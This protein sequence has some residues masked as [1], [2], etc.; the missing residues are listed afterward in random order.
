MAAT[1][2]PLGSVTGIQMHGSQTLSSGDG[3]ESLYSGG[4]KDT[5]E[6]SVCKMGSYL[7]SERMRLMAATVAGEITMGRVLERLCHHVWLHHAVI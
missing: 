1:L 4:Q 5:G 3:K 6:Q 2:P 7:P